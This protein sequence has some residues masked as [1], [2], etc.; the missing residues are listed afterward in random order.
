MAE[1]LITGKKA[2]RA[3]LL[4]TGV[5]VVTPLLAGIIPALMDLRIITLGTALSAGI[6]AFV[7]DLLLNQFI[8]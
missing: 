6:A 5:V 2:L 4:G 7:V 3:V 1:K 8:K